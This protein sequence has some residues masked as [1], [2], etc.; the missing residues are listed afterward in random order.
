MWFLHLQFCHVQANPPLFRNPYKA[1]SKILIAAKA[2]LNV[3]LP[4]VKDLEEAAKAVSDD[5]E[6]SLVLAEPPSPAMEI[7]IDNEEGSV[8]ENRETGSKKAW[9]SDDLDA[10]D[11]V[12]MC[13]QFYT[14]RYQ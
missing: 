5:K 12:Q 14:T 3:V 11:P 1:T 2:A 4:A 9:L 13:L 7:S 8:L 6:P 10:S